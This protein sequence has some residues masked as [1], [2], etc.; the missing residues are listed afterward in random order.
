MTIALDLGLGLEAPQKCRE[1]NL[2][3]KRLPIQPPMLG[4]VLYTLIDCERYYWTFNLKRD[5]NY[6]AGWSEAWPIYE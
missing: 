5:D 3:A 2:Q 4:N 1:Q 6:P